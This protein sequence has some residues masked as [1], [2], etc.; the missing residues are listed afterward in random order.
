MNNEIVDLL[1]ELTVIFF[2]EYRKILVKR[3]SVIFQIAQSK[4]LSAR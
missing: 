4:E 1:Q 3:V 2:E